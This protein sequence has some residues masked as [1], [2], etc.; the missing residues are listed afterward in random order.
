MA[1]LARK[2]NGLGFLAACL[3]DNCGSH[4]D[5]CVKQGLISESICVIIGWAWKLKTFYTVSSCYSHDLSMN[6]KSNCFFCP[7]KSKKHPRKKRSKTRCQFCKSPACP[8]HMDLYCQNCVSD[9]NQN[10]MIYHDLDCFSSHKNCSYFRHTL[11]ENELE[12][13]KCS[14]RTKLYCKFCLQ[15]FCDKHIF[16]VCQSCYQ[17]KVV[18]ETTSVQ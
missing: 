3:V 10:G 13:E 5:Q 12:T 11:V 8:D 14:Q 1:L 16:V 15:N 4:Q 2:S 17:L 6:A 18:K 9:L 7:K